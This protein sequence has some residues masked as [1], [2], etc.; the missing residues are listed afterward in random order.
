VQELF[1]SELDDDLRRQAIVYGQ[2]HDLQTGLMNFPAFQESLTAWMHS[3]PGNEAALIWIDVLNLR[4]EFALW[5][6]RGAEALIGRVAD[7]LRTA[8][9]SSGLVGRYS[10]RCFLVAL[11]AEAPA[12]LERRRIQAILDALSP[13]RVPG[14]HGMVEVA[15]GVAFWPANTKSLDDLIRFASIAASRAAY[16]KSRSVLPFRAGMDRLLM[17]DHQLEMEM[18]RAMNHNQF[19]IVYQ[20]KIELA[21]GRILGAEA[22][23]RWNHGR[24]GAVMP[25]EFI[26]VAERSDLIHLILDFTLRTAL[27]DARRWEQA[28][29]PMPLIAVNLSWANMRRD[30]F[31]SSLR[32]VLAEHPLS[33]TAVELEIT[34]SVL[35]DDEDLFDRRVRQLKDLGLRVAI[36]DF[37]TRYTGFNVLKRTPLDTLKI[38]RCFIHGLHRTDEARA[39]CHTIIA[40]GRQLR[41]RTVAEG[42]EEQPELDTLRALGCDAAQGFLI[43]R[44]TPAVGLA[45]FIREWPAWMHQLGF[46]SSGADRPSRSGI[47]RKKG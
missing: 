28:G 33:T 46:P 9:D 35:F 17:R 25:S 2:R 15:A 18:L 1:E 38:D 21:T 45:Q 11:K 27:E 31:L 30:D 36:D 40:M 14:T 37:G 42:V 8:V 34:E 41:L 24:W 12:R 26:P 7:I 6:R 5:G 32:E 47:E 20:P 22:L 3:R 19:R 43:R 13:M 10:T 23:I 44:P 29:V 4:R 39:L 16:V